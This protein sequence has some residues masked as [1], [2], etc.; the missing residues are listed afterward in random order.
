MNL[1]APIRRV[2]ESEAIEIIWSGEK[3]IIKRIATTFNIENSYISKI[4]V[5]YKAFNNNGFPYYWNSQ[6]RETTWNIPALLK[7][8]KDKIENPAKDFDLLKVP[9]NFIDGP[10]PKGI[11]GIRQLLK[12]NDPSDMESLRSKLKNFRQF[13]MELPEIEED[14]D[15]QFEENLIRAADLLAMYEHTRVFFVPNEPWLDRLYVSQYSLLDDIDDEMDG[16]DLKTDESIANAATEDVG[17]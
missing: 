10:V 3:S 8:A 17:F 12:S 11:G 7:E 5:W 13:L 1:P 9:E 16:G 15:G 2:G 14:N 6:T 4:Q